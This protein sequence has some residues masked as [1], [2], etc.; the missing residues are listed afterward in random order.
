MLRAPARYFPMK[1]G[2]YDVTAG[3]RPL[4]TDLGNGPADQ[5]IFQLDAD[6]SRYRAQKL[7]SRAERL[8]KYFPKPISLPPEA[9]ET[10]VRF[11]AERLVR[12]Y[13]EQFSLSPFPEGGATL[14]CRLTDE[15][16]A[17]S[18]NW[19]LLQ[20]ATHAE[21]VPAYRCAL[22]ALAGQIQED[23]AVWVREPGSAREWLGAVHLCFPN[24]WAAEEK[25]GRSFVAVH[26]PVAGFD[27]LARASESLVTSMIT[28]GPFV[29]FAW[30][31]ATDDRLNHHPVPPQGVA[32][33]DWWGRAFDPSEPRLHIRV[34]RQTLHPFSDVHAALFTIRTYF[35]DVSE[36]DKAEGE[37]QALALAIESMSP[38]ALRY[39][40]LSE[41]REAVLKWLRAGLPT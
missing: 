25:V 5:R 27:R 17:F 41:S 33:N 24:H 20:A 37:P 1:H 19:E 6:F 28:K 29:R 10:V 15:K 14:H 30:G 38:D 32:L 26:E 11:M 22:D 12:E 34:E 13:P 36:L 16:L 2:R 35:L 18:R 8:E 7:A 39:K 40:G 21:V 9:R 3:L 23:F 4:E 31:V